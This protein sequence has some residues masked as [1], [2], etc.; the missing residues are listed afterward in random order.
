MEKPL[1][2]F[3][4]ANNHCGSVEHGLNI[5]RGV[6]KAVEGFEDDFRFAIKFQYRDLSTFIHPDFKGR[7]DIKYVKRFS[8]T[9]L[10]KE[11]F[12][13]MLDEIR[14]LGLIAIC[15]PFDE[16]S[17]DLIEEHGFDY[18]KI[19]SCSLTDWP[20]LERIVKTDM[21]IIASTA[22]ASI[23]EID[24]VV[25]FF[26]NRKKNF[27]IMHCV[28]EYPTV[29]NNLNINQISL[30]KKRYENVTIG[31]STHEEPDNMDS[32][33][34]AIAKGARVFERHVSVKTDK[35]PM[36]AYSSTPEQVK[37]WVETAKDTY[38]MC[39][40]EDARYAG[41]E[42]ER[43]DLRGLKRGVWA[44]TDLKKGEKLTK[45]NVFFAIPCTEEQIVA[46]DM[47]K[48]MEYSLKKDVKAKE[49]LNFKDLEIKNK[50]EKVLHIIKMLREVLLKSHIALPG[51]VELELSHHYGID[52][53]E[54]YGAAIL[55]CIN[56]EYCKKL[57]VLLPGQKHPSHHHVKKEETFNV[58]YGDMELNLNGKEMELKAG[59]IVTVEREADHSFSSRGGCI[60]EE[61][62]TTHF[63][64]DS[65]YDDK[66]V[67]GNKDRK[68][69][70]TFWSDWLYKDLK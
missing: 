11:Q 42:K 29:R 61:V 51:K 58:L 1:F 52:K 48:Y 20:L 31:F 25:S 9:A 7:Q 46:N 50:R 63:K 13:I 56:R 55:N 3:D 66:E 18:I 53:Y 5:I 2:V 19:G 47:S 54:E 30:L 8:E 24:H 16:N 39:G 12:K 35:Y 4:L 28:G 59:E 41:T 34:I 10:S 38:D 27:V 65:F 32:I 70:M 21:P 44:K 37:K 68:T 23:E 33:R 6:K 36:N 49:P 43:T 57:I 15:T 64:D 17:V 45:E 26:Q 62:S 14:K 69:Q 67:A 22:G 40:I 60:F